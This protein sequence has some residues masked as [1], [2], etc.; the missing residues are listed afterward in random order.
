[1]DLKTFFVTEITHSGEGLKP[2][3]C[4]L[5]RITA[6]FPPACIIFGI[7]YVIITYIRYLLVQY[8]FLISELKLSL[9]S[10][11]STFIYR[12]TVSEDS[13]QKP[14]GGSLDHA[15]RTAAIHKH[16]HLNVSDRISGAC[17]EN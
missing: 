16:I 17:I 3:A 4:A 11:L 1:M 9:D 12:A 5:S 7:P 13:K 15:L 2:S 14:R 10:S 6:P 8:S